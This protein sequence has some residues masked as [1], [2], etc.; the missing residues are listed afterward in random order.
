M[1]LILRFWG[2]LYIFLSN[3]PREFL[4]EL[5]FST[6]LLILIQFLNRRMYT[7]IQLNRDSYEPWGFRLCGGIESEQP[8][9]I[10]KVWIEWTYILLISKF[11]LSVLFNKSYYLVQ[12]INFRL[13]TQ[14][15]LERKKL[16]CSWVSRNP[17]KTRDNILE[18]LKKVSF[19]YKFDDDIPEFYT[20]QFSL[21]SNSMRGQRNSLE[22]SIPIYVGN[23]NKKFQ[24]YFS[25]AGTSWTM[26]NVW[27]KSPGQIKICIT[28]FCI[29][30]ACLCIF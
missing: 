20:A 16:C 26:T 17:I 13:K 30:W 2:R 7:D 8:L 1:C 11:F 10:I 28:S 3:F 27:M 4:W 9:T 12:N 21:K 18:N 19:F 29:F 5:L 25:M 24:I 22:I 23:G 6:K 14:I 15:T